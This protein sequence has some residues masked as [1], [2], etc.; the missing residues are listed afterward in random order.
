MGKWFC[1]VLFTIVG[2]SIGIPLVFKVAKG[3]I[4][5]AAPARG[6]YM[7]GISEVTSHL[8]QVAETEVEPSLRFILLQNGTNPNITDPNMHV[9]MN[10]IRLS[11]ER[12]EAGAA[13]FQS[14]EDATSQWQAF[15]D[16]R[17]GVAVAAEL[18][19]TCNIDCSDEDFYS[20]CLDLL[21]DH[22]QAWVDALK[23]CFQY[24]ALETNRIQL[25]PWGALSNSSGAAKP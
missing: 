5:D 24:V 22:A 25:A 2:V 13:M 18:A 3:M 21:L 15:S 14:S 23:L 19:V 1:L 4:T 16:L 12:L 10:S 11:K 9:C 7:A 17:A 6:H 20:G 8:L